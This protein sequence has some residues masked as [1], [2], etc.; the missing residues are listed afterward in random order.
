MSRKISITL[1]DEAQAAIAEILHLS[2][3][4]LTPQKLSAEKIVQAALRPG[5]RKDL[6]TLRR[7]ATLSKRWS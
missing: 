6:A 4:G 3:E 2:G 7:A 1:D 5:L